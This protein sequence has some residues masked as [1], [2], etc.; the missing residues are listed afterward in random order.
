MLTFKHFIDSPAWAAVDGY[1]FSVMDSISVA[2]INTDVFFNASIRVWSDFPNWEM[3]ELPAQFIA[4]IIAT[5]A[6]ITYPLTFWIFGIA[7]HINLKRHVRKYQKIGKSQIV[8][9]NLK[10]W[11]ED[12]DRRFANG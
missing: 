11:R 7:L 9:N 5:A 8:I 3:R 2:A 4:G 6:A 1:K 10:R 12:C